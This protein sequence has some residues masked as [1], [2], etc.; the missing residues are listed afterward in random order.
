MTDDG[1]QRRSPLLGIA[2]LK[3]GGA[4]KTLAQAARHNKREGGTRGRLNIDPNRSHSNV[5]ISGPDTADGVMALQDQWMKA[6]GAKERKNGVAAIELLFTLPAG[7]EGDPLTYFRDCDE[8][9]ESHFEGCRI[10][11]SDIH[12]DESRPHCHVLLFPPVV[13]GRTR[14][15]DVEGHGATNAA[16]WSAFH[17]FA[18]REHGVKVPVTLHPAIRER[19]VAL[20]V[21]HLERVSD[22]ATK[23]ATWPAIRASIGADPRPFLTA[24]GIPTP[25]PL[26]RPRTFV[27]IMIGRGKGAIWGNE[28]SL[29]M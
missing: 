4:R 24:L 9:A 17:D 19:A 8:W 29:L 10:L 18:E 28:T 12:M 23:S 20:V 27:Q 2:K 3:F 26:S 21:A 1:Y 22:P 25:E 6:A 14:G 7:F 5:C 11:S 16:H 15:S 13:D